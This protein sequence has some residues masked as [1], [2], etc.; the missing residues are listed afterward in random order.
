[1]GGFSGADP[2]DVPD[3]TDEIPSLEAM[4]SEDDGGEMVVISGEASCEKCAHKRVCA[5]YS[6]VKPMLDGM[7]EKTGEEPPIDAERLAWICE[8]YT[9]EEEDG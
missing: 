7:I 2:A 5:I 6:G 4:M 3:D 8:E 9:P 1:M